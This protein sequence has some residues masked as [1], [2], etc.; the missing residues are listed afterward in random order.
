MIGYILSP[1][2]SNRNLNNIML[3]ERDKAIRLCGDHLAEVV[4][5]V[6]EGRFAEPAKKKGSPQRKY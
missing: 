6:C 4:S 3:N 1:A 2:S 5:F